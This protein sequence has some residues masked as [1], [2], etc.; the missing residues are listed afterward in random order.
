MED[1]PDLQAYLRLLFSGSFQVVTAPNGAQALEL[2]AD[3][4]SFPRGCDLIISDLMMPVMDGFQLLQRL[5]AQD[6]T[7]HIPVIMLTARADARDKLKALRIGV[8]DYL[9]K[10]FNEEELFARVNNLLENRKR[11]LSA[12]S[13]ANG[14]TSP[15][16]PHNITDED[17]EWLTE[18]E[19]FVL[20]KIG[21]DTLD[22]PSLSEH[23]AMSESSLLRRLKRLTGLSPKQYLLEVRLNRARQLLEQRTH[24][25][26][27]K[28]AY[29]VGYTHTPSF[30]RQFK[31]RFGKSPAD[32]LT[33]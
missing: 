33:P 4:E 9:L 28:I 12:S 15:A 31:K 5:K 22:I 21:D 7:R 25:S 30:S 3:A 1:N 10:P 18:F 6:A 20:E 32:Y 29:E 8:D 27:A 11:R 24:S 14:R 19:E 13:R 16:C 2:L 26:I 17:Q 23:F